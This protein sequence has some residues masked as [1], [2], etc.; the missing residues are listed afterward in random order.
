M[1]NQ[2]NEK[3]KILYIG[4]DINIIDQFEISGKFEI[5]KKENSLSAIRW[6]GENK[7]IDAIL[8]E[9]YIPGL[10]GIDIF[11]FLKSKNLHPFTPFILINHVFEQKIKTEAFTNKIDDYYITPLNSDTIF[12]RINFLKKYKI[13]LSKQSVAKSKSV[14]YKIPFSKRMF[15]IL[16]SGLALLF[17]SPFLLL[18][19]LA[20]RIEAKGNIFYISKRVGTGYKVFDFYKFRSMYLGAD[21]KLAGLKHLNQYNISEE[22]EDTLSGFEGKCEDCEKLGHPCSPI[23][24]IAGK[25]I[26][27][28]YYLKH[29]RDKSKSTFIKIKND[30]RVTKVGKF[31]R[32]MSLDELPQLINV[33][34]GDMSIVGNRPLPLYEAELLTSDEWGERFLGPAGITGLWQVY[35]RGKSDMSEDERKMLDNQYAQNNSFWGDIKIIL[36]TIPAIFQ[37]ENV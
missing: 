27:E 1:D 6:L 15:D 29:K 21:A 9:M 33:L 2:S 26:C 17:L 22:E 35:K 20:I 13:F 34:K 10:N 12:F 37:K 19:A 18:I 7:F 32:N 14:E 25:E 5:I 31:L 23:L 8:C 3:L 4:G 28:R 24:F 30:P 16:L 11:K 36:M